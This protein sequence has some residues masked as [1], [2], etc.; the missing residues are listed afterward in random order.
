METHRSL[1][2]V[3]RRLVL[4]NGRAQSTFYDQNRTKIYDQNQIELN[5]YGLGMGMDRYGRAVKHDPLLEY[6]PN[7]Y[8]LGVGMDQF[9]RP[10]RLYGN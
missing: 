1:H 2:P 6:T 4:C 5:A 8:G 10:V 3:S 7:A 9:G